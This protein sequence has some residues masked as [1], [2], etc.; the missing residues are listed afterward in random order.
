[1]LYK[2]DTNVLKKYWK[3]VRPEQIT[4]TLICNLDQ[5]LK[6]NLLKVQLIDYRSF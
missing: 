3:D 1:M 4:D 5:D 2:T 6:K